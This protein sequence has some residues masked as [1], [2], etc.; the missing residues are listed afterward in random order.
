M[1]F[2]TKNAAGS[3]Y[4]TVPAGGFLV[5]DPQ[6]WGAI[7][8]LTSDPEELKQH[9]IFYKPDTQSAHE[10]YRQMTDLLAYMGHSV[11]DL[12]SLLKDDQAFQEHANANPN[13][14]FTRDSSI[15]VPFPGMESTVIPGLM[16]LSGR[17]G[18]PSFV[19]EGLDSLG[20][21]IHRLNL[22][23]Q[24]LLEGG[25]V[26]PVILD[27][28]K[29]LL[30]G[31]GERTTL[32]SAKVIAD[33]LPVDQVIAIGHPKD[34]LHLDTGLAFYPG[35]TVQAEGMF[36]W[37]L[38]LR[39]GKAPEEFDIQQH[40]KD[41][42][43]TPLVV[44]REE[45]I[46]MEVCN[47]LALGDNKYLAFQETNPELINKLEDLTGAN[48]ITTPGHQLALMAGGV[49]CSTRPLYGDGPHEK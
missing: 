36:E 21:N 3:E 48:V 40:L 29:T 12:A 6:P 47:V 14:F 37:A 42:G 23:E 1:S 45:A 13:F 27:G 19:A 20:Y 16:Y 9:G 7:E 44:S 46:D 28:E 32:E 33:E 2:N 10:Q 31:I 30:V 41:C 39:K 24:D 35:A 43:Y 25:D 18:E 15:T 17:K 38:R 34:I 26:I 5:L 8:Q 49:H 4:L 22:G 11:I